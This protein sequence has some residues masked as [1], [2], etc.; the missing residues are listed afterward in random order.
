[1]AVNTTVRVVMPEM[2]ESVTEGIVLEW[3]KAEGEPIAAD[4]TLVEISTDKVDAE[5]PAPAGGTV[6]KIHVAEGETVEVGALLAEIATDGAAAGNGAEPPA[7]A[8]GPATRRP[9]ARRPPVTARA[10]RLRRRPR[11]TARPPPL[12]RPRRPPGGSSRSPCRRWASR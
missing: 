10:P 9:R 12:R 6:A 5:V 7:A 8:T 3:L 11:T 4:E 2:G 1:M